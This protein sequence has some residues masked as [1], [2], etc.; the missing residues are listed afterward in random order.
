MKVLLVTLGT[1]GDVHPFIGLGLALR[2]R[3]HDVILLANEHYA[4]R[5]NGT[6]NFV[7]L[8]SKSLHQ[9]IVDDPAFW[10]PTRLGSVVAE[11]GL[12]QM[13][14]QFQAIEENYEPGRTVVVSPASVFGARIAQEKL[15]VPLATVVLQPALFR[16]AYRPAV[17]EWLTVERQYWQL[18]KNPNS[19]ACLELPGDTAEQVPPHR[20]VPIGEIEC[21]RSAIAVEVGERLQE[22]VAYLQFLDLIEKRIEIG[23]LL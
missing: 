21:V 18:R 2:E 16:S 1:D 17:I 22:Y 8:G 14:A 3:G 15:G 7:T 5:V 13:P 4:D 11:W 10:D 12:S 9:R 19:G 20:Q 23:F 6:L